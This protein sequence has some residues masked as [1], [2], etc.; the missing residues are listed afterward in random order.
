[1]QNISEL[2]LNPFSKCSHWSECENIRKER[3][4]RLD[5][6]VNTTQILDKVNCGKYNR[7]YT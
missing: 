5:S 3:K 4:S 6:E 1:M 2:E 7:T